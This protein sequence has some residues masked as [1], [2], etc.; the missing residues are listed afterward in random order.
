MRGYW[1]TM[2]MLAMA[3][4]VADEQ[5]PVIAIPETGNPPSIDGTISE[6]E[7]SRAAVTCGFRDVTTGRPGRAGT[8]VSLCYDGRA[9]YVLFECE[10]EGA[11]AGGRGGERDSAIWNGP[12]AELFLAPADWPVTDYAHFMVAADSTIADERVSAVGRDLSWNP[13]WRAATAPAGDGWVAEL[14]IPWEPLSVDATRSGTVF[15]ACMARNAP[16]LDELSAWSPVR[17]GFHDPERFGTLRLAGGEPVVA[18]R[19]LPGRQLGETELT[20]RRTGSRRGLRVRVRGQSSRGALTLADTE[21][22]AGAE[23]RAHRVT[24]DVAGGTEW[25]EVEVTSPDG[26]VA[27]RQ[28]AGLA[29]PDLA[30]VAAALRRRLEGS[31]VP[32]G[33]RQRLGARLS[34]IVDQADGPLDEAGIDAAT[35]ELDAVARETTDSVGLADARAM[36]GGNVTFYV[37]NPIVTRKIQPDTADPGP[38]ARSL[39]ID[40]A[41]NEFE[42][43]QIVVCAVAEPLASVRVSAGGLRGPGEAQIPA[44]RVTVSP[45]GFVRSAVRTPGASLEGELPDV[46]LPDRPME[47]AKGRRQPFLITIRTTDDDQPGEYRGVVR[48]R[49]TGGSVDIPLTVRV[50]DVAIPTKSTLRTAFVLWGHF[51]RFVSEPGPEA[52]FETYLR[53]SEVM[54]EHRI[55]PITM[56]DPRKDAEGRWDFSDY[57]RL[58]TALVP[59]G[60][61]TVNLGGNGRVCGDRNTEFVRAAEEHLKERGW[62]DLHYIYGHDEAAA[63]SLGELQANYKALVDAVPD[64]KIMQ[65]GWNPTPGLEGLV[66]IWCPL[67]ALADMNAIRQAQARGDEVWW[68]VCCGPVAPYANLFVDYAGIDHRILGWQTFR[69]GIEGLL[70]W[71]VD[72][73]PGNEQPLEEYDRNNYA[74]WN[75]N[76]FG[77]F[78]GDGYLMYP[79]RNGEPL[80]SLRLALLRDG[81]EDY[82]L[83]ARVR[84]LATGKGDLAARARRLL[85]LDAPLITSLVEYARDGALLLERRQA[86]L[87]VGEALG[88]RE[89]GP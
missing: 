38:V 31:G 18:V 7:W 71:G 85:M 24:F 50:Y 41:R 57:D 86:I 59:K 16:S 12:L 36:A 6:G 61:T 20:L 88:Q 8:I 56:W 21:L 80:A 32:A 34:P 33:D 70:Y 54:L 28:T 5:L 1:L 43:V 66:R 75:P 55:S 45:I 73:W 46:L 68:Y 23:A 47:V 51:A 39:Y 15:R 63:G 78:N 74:Q 52:Y 9:L 48:V 81:L 72:V 11:M 89:S 30:A 77:S 64:L 53:Y 25:L 84:A 62:W 58:L 4:C 44:G 69:Y 60:L 40:M 26:S 67:T 87:E 37:T 49:T 82:E 10:G 19:A 76:S 27:W 35:A 22:R 29:L 14:A 3:P 17:G 65:T 2:V 13:E 42:P 79:G 83:M